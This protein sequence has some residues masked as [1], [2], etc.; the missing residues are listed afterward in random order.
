MKENTAMT[1]EEI[2][3]KHL[4]KNGLSVNSGKIGEAIQKSAFDAMQEYADQEKEKEA[5]EF[6]DFLVKNYQP[7][8]P[9]K[10]E[11]VKISDSN[12]FLKIYTIT[13]LY[14]EHKKYKE[15]KCK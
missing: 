7:R 6:A 12:K 9:N 2:R 10:S 4:Y 1:K 13:E 5:V 14:N 11:W 15:I 3:N 8:F